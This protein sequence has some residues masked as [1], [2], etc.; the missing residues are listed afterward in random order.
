MANATI[1]ASVSA[2]TRK[3]CRFVYAAEVVLRL[4]L[5]GITALAVFAAVLNTSLPRTVELRWCSTTTPSF[6]T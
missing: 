1:A 4:L 6:R 5:P 2:E 3:A